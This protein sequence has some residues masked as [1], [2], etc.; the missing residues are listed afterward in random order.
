MVARQGD[1]GRREAKHQSLNP[2]FYTE[3]DLD[4]CECLW[5][6]RWTGL[7]SDASAFESP[8]AMRAGFEVYRAFS[9]DHRSMS[10]HL[11]GS[12]RLQLPVLATGG[13]ASIMTQVSLCS[14]DWTE[15]TRVAAETSVDRR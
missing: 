9:T 12:T 11:A 15:R 2:L 10:E 14:L 8:G 13:E 3:D 5:S 1:W 7:I 4:V 6:I